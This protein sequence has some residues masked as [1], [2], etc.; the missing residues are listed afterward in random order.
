MAKPAHV[1]YLVGRLPLARW[2]Q[3]MRSLPFCW[4]DA[5]VHIHMGRGRAVNRLTDARSACFPFNFFFVSCLHLRLPHVQT[6]R[7]L[8][9]TRR[10]LRR[11]VFVLLFLEVLFQ[12]VGSVAA[13]SQHPH[14]VRVTTFLCPR[15]MIRVPRNHLTLQRQEAY[16]EAFERRSSPADF[17]VE[18][19]AWSGRSD[20]KQPVRSWA[21]PSGSIHDPV[22]TLASGVRL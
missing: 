4:F 2:L 9:R 3:E 1:S 10:R 15:D 16:G 19:L 12:S 18:S 5:G 13:P 21:L 8:R 14:Y 22:M 6:R 17:S 20:Q 11:Y 7:R